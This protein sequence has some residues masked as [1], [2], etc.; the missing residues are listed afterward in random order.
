[1]TAKKWRN[2]LSLK[3][4]EIK[5]ACEFTGIPWNEG[6]TRNDFFAAG[7]ASGLIKKVKFEEWLNNYD[8]EVNTP[9]EYYEKPKKKFEPVVEKPKEPSAYVVKMV[10]A[11]PTFIV[12]DRKFTKEHPYSLFKDREE[13]DGFMASHQGFEI[14][15]EDELRRYYRK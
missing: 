1:M 15:S 3:K 2:M 6:M 13:L 8:P 14:V 5:G 9:D 12:G 10:R 11:N 4:E 7:R